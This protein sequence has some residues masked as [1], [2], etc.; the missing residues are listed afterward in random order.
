MKSL[1]KLSNKS[2]ETM[3]T[4]SMIQVV[5]CFSDVILRGEP[6]PM[7]SIYSIIQI[8]KVSD[9]KRQ[10]NTFTAYVDSYISE[11]RHSWRLSLSLSIGTF[12]PLCQNDNH[13]IKYQFYYT[14]KSSKVVEFKLFL[15]VES[16][17]LHEML[18]KIM[19]WE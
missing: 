13:H 5:R 10:Q 15:V 19:V 9:P 4:L 11:R 3:D 1:S 2:W 8:F 17:I 6:S 12:L 7:T 16:I 14:L 18:N